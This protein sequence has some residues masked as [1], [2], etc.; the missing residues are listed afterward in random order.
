MRLMRMLPETIDPDTRSDAERTLYRRLALVEDGHWP[1]ALH[2]LNLAEHRWKRTGEID[3]LLL[4]EY[5]IYVLEVKGGAVTCERGV[6]RFTN[7]YGHVTRKRA[8]PFSQAGTAMYALQERLE[9]LLEPSLVGRTTF[10]YGV[11]FPD[12]DF[13]IEGVEWAPEMVLDRHQ[14]DRPD[15]VLRSLNRLARYWRAKPGSRDRVLTEDDMR[16]Y[17][18]VLRPEYEVVP[19]LQRIADAAEQEL[20]VLTSRQYDALDAHARNERMLFEGGA[21]TGKSMLAVELCRRQARDGRRVLFTCES[22]LVASHI[23]AQPGMSGVTVCTTES[24]PEVTE[25]F[26]VLVV[27]E[28]QDVMNVDRLLRLE[29][30]LKG[31]LQDGRWYFFLDGNNQRGLIGSYDQDGEDYLLAARPA[32]LHLSDNC[33]N[34]ATIVEKVR[35]LTGADV[36]VSTAGTGPRVEV[37]ATSGAKTA[38]KAVGLILDR[39][40]GDGVE[41]DRIMLLSP[42]PLADSAFARMPG[43]WIQRIDP[44]DARSW[45]SRPP[46]RLGFATIADFKGLESPFVILADVVLPESAPEP[47]SRLYVGMTRARV[48]LHIVPTS[49][50]SARQLGGW[51]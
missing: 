25:D 45:A 32:R 23:A 38:G 41:P 16:R 46:S 35:E 19:T 22:P 51:K 42:L 12:Q 3:F 14:L 43:K 17:L 27:D 20:A 28:A 47:S 31:G 36:G 37:V 49:G 7:R 26:D 15:G 29:D 2:S 40:V 1:V 11:V 39:L 48:G 24:I 9:G 6:W 18:E 21:G 13:S 44:V 50:A 5:G 10:G 30:V 4:S 34:T 8:S 33:R